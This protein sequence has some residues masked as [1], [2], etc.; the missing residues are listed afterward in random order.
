MLCAFSLG[1]LK[2]LSVDH[3]GATEDA[4]K[5]Q[6]RDEN[7]AGAHPAIQVKTDKKTETNAAGHGEADLQN[8]GEVFG[9]NPVFFIVEHLVLGTAWGRTKAPVAWVAQR[10]DRSM[11]TTENGDPPSIIMLH[12]LKLSLV[13]EGSSLKSYLR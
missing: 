6:Y 7:A 1:N 5:R 9:P 3:V 4:E 11:G 12:F 10:R 13:D 8:D 2:D